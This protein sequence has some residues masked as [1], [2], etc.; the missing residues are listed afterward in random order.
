MTE[1]YYR[2][3]NRLRSLDEKAGD[4]YCWASLES[5]AT[6]HD[7]D[8]RVE[9]EDAESLKEN[10]RSVDSC[11]REGKEIGSCWCGKFA[12]TTE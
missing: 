2:N 12:N 9:A 11:K 6:A 10:A 7:G 5:V 4:K 8:K 1:Q 3:V